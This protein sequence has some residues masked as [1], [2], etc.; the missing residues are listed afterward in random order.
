MT[1]TQLSFPPYSLRETRTGNGTPVVLLHGLSG[2]SRWW[3]RNIDALAAEHLVVAV[4]LPRFVP[5]F[6]E[7]TALLARWLETFGEPVH[8]IGHSMGGQLAIALTAERPDLVRSLILVNAAGMPFKLDPRP[9][10]RAVP[11]PPYGGASIAR[12]LLPDFFR[13][14][15]ASVAVSGARVVR[16]DMRAW[17]HAIRVPTLLVWGENDPLVPL[18]YGEAMQQEIAG[19][20]LIAIPG[21]AHVT[22]W[23]T[24]S[25]FNSIALSFLREASSLPLTPTAPVFSWGLSGF[26]NGIAHRQSGRGRDIVLVHG[27]GMSSAYFIHLARELFARGFHPIAPD[28]P[29][30]GESNDAPA[31]APDVHARW[32]AS[33][34]DAVGIRNAIWLGHSTG[35]N[36]VAHVASLR[37]DLVS[38][39]VYVGPIWTSRSWLRIFAMLTL[40]AFREPLS[41]YRHV[42]RAYWRAG[43]A[44]WWRT[45]RAFIPDLPTRPAEGT[46]LAG[47]RDPL[48]DRTFVPVREVEGAHACVFSGAGEVAE[49]VRSEDA[50]RASRAT[51]PESR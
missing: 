49:G 51:T 45:W 23:D 46:F 1:T 36:A 22:M 4:D 31:V 25:D 50:I 42:I 47:T 11:H 18:V 35:C 9:H 40:D 20:R 38:R 24:P 43:I 13:T 12:V 33:W 26:T 8:L 2:S 7:T 10:V 28:L 30:F 17:M 41:L 44:R 15:P 6:G 5:S 27:L 14:G 3:S 37:P 16:A 29:G 19:S 34:A 48:P 39:A 21:A 32:L